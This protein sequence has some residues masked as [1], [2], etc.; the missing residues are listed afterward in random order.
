M[1][2]LGLY[3]SVPFCKAKCTFCNFASDAFPPE[4]MAGYV[5]RLCGE[6]DGARTLAAR[7][8]MT[9]PLAVD[10]IF[11]GGGTPSLLEPAQMHRLFSV[12]RSNFEVNA[13]AEVTVEAAPRQIA[14][15]L[16]DAMLAGGVNCVSLGV[17]SF[18]DAESRAVGR[19]HTGAQC[20][21]ELDRLRAAGVSRLNVD[22][23]AGL[24]HQTRASWAES[25]QQA[26]G[27]GVEHVSIYMLEVDEDS[28]LGR[29]TDR[30]GHTVWSPC[31]TG[32]VAGRRTL[33]AGMRGARGRGPAAVRDLQLR[34]PGLS[35]TP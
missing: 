13:D 22:L 19:M 31:G 17:Q 2:T 12:V 30:T 10:S 8:G 4:R 6:L 26:I 32:R 35:I 11:M 33:H 21:A 16:L 34:T 27:S 14:G 23:I 1:D 20:L 28:R 24:P 29:R 3:L 9:V 25:L 15:E 5:D 7:L 18:V